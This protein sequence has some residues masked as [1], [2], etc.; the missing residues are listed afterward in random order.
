MPRVKKPTPAGEPPFVPPKATGSAKARRSAARL[1]AVQ[2][3]Y[4]MEMAGTATETVIGEFVRHRIGQ[5]LDGDTLVTAEP[6]LFADIVRGVSVREMEI[7]GILT[8]ALTGQW[9]L[10][11]LEPL[12]RAVLRAGVWE[13]LAK[14]DTHQAILISSYVDVTHAFFSGKEPGMVNGV[15]DR[16]ARTLRPGDAAPAP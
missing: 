1:A 12:L 5:E 15:L 11:R 2:A 8:Q 14:T 3:L 9:S 10:T 7:D 6:Q 13:L 16:L 4:Q